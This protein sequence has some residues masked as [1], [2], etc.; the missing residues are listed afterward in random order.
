[1]VRVNIIS[2]NVRK[3]HAFNGCDGSTAWISLTAAIA[4]IE[5][6]DGSIIVFPSGDE[7]LLVSETPDELMRDEWS[8]LADE[9][10]RGD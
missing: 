7:W 2:A 10:E 5:H 3:E 1:M 8:R 6:R 9:L 4:V